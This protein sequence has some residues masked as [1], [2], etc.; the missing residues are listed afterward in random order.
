VSAIHNFGAS[1]L[2]EIKA[3]A[4]DSLLMPFTDATVPEIDLAARRIVIV[5][6]TESE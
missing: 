1:D 2:I 3:L 6:P 5:P 4:G